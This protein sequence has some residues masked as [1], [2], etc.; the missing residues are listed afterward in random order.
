MSPSELP[1]NYDPTEV[2]RRWYD[3]WVD[4]GYFRPKDGDGAP[5]VI[6]I[7][8]PNVTGSLHFGHVFD[9]TIQDLLSRWQRMTGVPLAR[10]S[11]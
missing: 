9:H 7:P 2:E 10:P 3:H 4:R 8:P 6:T 1:K 5:F 11:S